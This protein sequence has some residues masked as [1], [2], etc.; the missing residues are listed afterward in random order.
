MTTRPAGT[1][2]TIRTLVRCGLA[3][4]GTVCLFCF[5]T[6][7]GKGGHGQFTFNVGSPDHWLVWTNEG[8]TFALNRWSVVIGILGVICW[9]ACFRLR[10][11]SGSSDDDQ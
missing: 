2:I 4:F 11:K 7:S 8:F 3:I 5:L 10:R 9:S 6:F 1:A